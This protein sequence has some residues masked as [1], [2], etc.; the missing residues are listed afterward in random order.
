MFNSNNY[1]IC[2]HK[3]KKKKNTN[4]SDTDFSFLLMRTLIARKH[5]LLKIVESALKIVC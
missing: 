5:V 3:N 2:I 4:K 1:Y